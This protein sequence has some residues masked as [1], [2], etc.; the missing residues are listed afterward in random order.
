MWFRRCGVVK[1]ELSRFC[2]FLLLRGF[3]CKW[4][5]DNL[6]TRC[7]ADRNII[8]VEIFTVGELCYVMLCYVMLCYLMLCYVM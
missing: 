2:L 6:Q 5:T 7:L 3:T 4:Y 8:L 1:L